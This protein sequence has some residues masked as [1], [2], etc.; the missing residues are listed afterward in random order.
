M[1]RH[2]DPVDEHV[3]TAVSITAVICCYTAKRRTSLDAAMAAVLGQLHSRDELVVVVDGNPDLYRELVDGRDEVHDDRLTLLQ[4]RFAPGLSGARNTGLHRAAGDVVVFLDDDAVLATAALDGVRT[5]FDDPTVTALGGAVRPAWEA[6]TQ[7][8]WFPP[9]FGW[10]VG[11]DYRGLPPD[12]AAIRNPIGAAMA[13]RRVPLLEID[14][15]SD[16]LG[17]VGTLPT[18]CEETMMGIELSRRDPHARIIRH[19]AF[20]VTHDVPADRTTLS[21]FVRRCFHEGRS[22]AVLTRLCG[23][24]SSLRSERA[25]ATRT[26]PTGVWNARRR[27]SRIAAL[28]TGLGATAL[29][30]VMGLARIERKAVPS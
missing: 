23:Q 13:V 19:T 14:G 7:P 4:N 22:K 8:R 25:F 5:A 11:C 12:G 9:E 24:Q 20:A 3:A 15:F 28:V 2:A 1:T 21:Y 29:G 17:R 27:P 18:G 10:V 6:G 26:L 30:Y 16:R